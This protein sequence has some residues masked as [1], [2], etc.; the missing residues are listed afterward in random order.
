MSPAE[1]REV[2]RADVVE[3]AKALLG[4]TLIKGELR[5]QIVEVEAYRSDDPASHSF[6]GRSPRTEVMHGEPGFAYVYFNYGVHWMFNIVAHPTGDGSAVLIR[7]AIPLAG[8]DVMAEGRRTQKPQSL[9]S[10]PGKL[11][12]A[13]AITGSDNG[14]DLLDPLS[15]LHIEPAAALCT[16][17]ASGPRIG[18]AVGK[19]HDVP[20]RFID[21]DQTAWLSVPLSRS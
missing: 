9:L 15:P 10:G 1:L 20:W 17:I 2:L 19:W 6:R 7:A 13:F 16:N 18:I 4:A 21:A 11:A 12:Q 14:L 5:A 8:Q 3:G